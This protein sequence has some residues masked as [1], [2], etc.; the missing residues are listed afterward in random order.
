MCKQ[1][2]SVMGCLGEIIGC[3]QISVSGFLFM[4]QWI[5]V[6]FFGEWMFGVN[7]G[8][9]CVVMQGGLNTGCSRG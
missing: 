4:H 5:S 7:A 1:Y 6:E 8:V 3:G 2:V 9:D